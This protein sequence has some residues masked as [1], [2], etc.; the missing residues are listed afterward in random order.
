M[1][2]SAPPCL[3]SSS[4]WKIL[5]DYHIHLNLQ[6]PAVVLFCA[7]SHLCPGNPAL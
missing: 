6:L 2:L 3:S 5:L 1:P 4:F 7:D